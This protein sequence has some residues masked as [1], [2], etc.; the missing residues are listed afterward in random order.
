MV[1]KSISELVEQTTVKMDS[2]YDHFIVRLSQND[3]DKFSDYYD[4]S[5]KPIFAYCKTGTR[6]SMLW[7]LSESGKR[8]K[9][10]ILKLTTAAGYNLSSLF[11]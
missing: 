11:G 7:A 5:E 6:S 4:E 9:D 3:I 2:L 8:S 10:E 1:T